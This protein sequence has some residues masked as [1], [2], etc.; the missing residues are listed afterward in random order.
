MRYSI[1]TTANQDLGIQFV[2]D[3]VNNGRSLDENGNPVGD[4]V[5]AETYLTARFGEVLDSYHR[6]YAEAQADAAW[7]AKLAE[8]IT[9]AQELTAL[10][11]AKAAKLAEIQ[12]D[13][14]ASISAGITPSG[15]AIVLA[16]GDS[17]VSKFTQLATLLREVESL[18]PTEEAKAAFRSS[19]VTVADI[20][21][22][23]HQVTVQEFRAMIVDY[24]IQ[25][26]TLWAAYTNKKAQI[27]QAQTVEEVEAI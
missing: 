11:M 5:T 3:K 19:S 2:V 10:E 20:Q 7:D 4:P 27:S 1:D 17:D 8:H 6:A 22:E 18:Q 15:S 21:G 14:R 9:P 16:A 23:T 25:V 12:S 13:Y 24:G 26:N